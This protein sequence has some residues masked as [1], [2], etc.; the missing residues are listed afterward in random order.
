MGGLFGKGKNVSSSAPVISSLRLQTSAKGKVIPVAFGMPRISPNIIDYQDFTAIPHTETQ[1]SGGGKGGNRTTYS[2][3]TYT[4]TVCVLMGLCYGPIAAIARAWVDKQKYTDITK[5]GF[6]TY[7]GT[8]TQMP[9][10][11]MQTKHADRALGYRNIAYVAASTYDLGDSATL[12]NHSFEIDTGTGFSA[13]IRDASPALIVASILTNARYGVGFPASRI[14]DLS[15]FGDY[16]AAAGLF[17]SPVYTDS[18]TAQSVILELADLCDTDVCFAGGKLQFK[19]RATTA[20]SGNGK[21]FTPYLT[22]LYHLTDDDFLE[23]PRIIRNSNADAPNCVTLKFNNRDTDYN[24]EIVEAKDQANIEIFGLHKDQEIAADA[25]VDS[26]VAARVVQLRLQRKLYRRNQYEFTIGWKYALLE[27]CDIVTLTDS[28]LGLDRQAVR[29]LSVDEDEWGAL[30]ITAEEFASAAPAGNGVYTD[31]Y[32]PDYN[33]PADTC[34]VPA[35]FELAQV[36]PQDESSLGIAVAGNGSN[37]GGC[38]VW[39][40]WDGTNYKNVGQITAPCRYGSLVGSVGNAVNAV[41]PVALTGTNTTLVSASDVAADNF[42]T[43]CLVGDELC[44]YSKATLVSAGRYDVSLRSRGSYGTAAIAHVSGDSF[45][46]LDEAVFWHNIPADLIGS[47]LYIKLTAYNIYFAGEQSL[48]DVAAYQVTLAGPSNGSGNGT[49]TAPIGFVLAAPFVGAVCSIKWDKLEDVTAYRLRIYDT[50]TLTLR[51]TVTLSDTHFDYSY[52]MATDDGGPWRKLTFRL[53]S[54]NEAE[55]E[56][57]VYA[58]LKVE[59]PQVGL[60]TGLKVTGFP[61]QI[62][63]EYA[64]PSSDAAGILVFV[65][66]TPGFVPSVSTRVY[67]GRDAVIGITTTFAGMQYVRVAGYDYWGKDSLTYSPEMSVSTAQWNPFDLVDGLEPVQIVTTLP[68][69]YAWEGS[70][71]ISCSGMLYQLD[72][73]QWVPMVDASKLSGKITSTQIT[74]G[75]V[76]TPKLAAGAVTAA[77]IAANAVTAAKIQA[78][79]VSA[80]KIAANAIAATNIQAGAVTAAKIAVATLSAIAANIGSIISGK[81]QNASGSALFDLDATGLNPFIRFRDSLANDV[82]KVSADGSVYARGDIQASSLKANTAMVDTL[83]IKDAAISV[84]SSASAGGGTPPVGIWMQVCDVT[85]KFTGSGALVVA[86]VDVASAGLAVVQDGEN[87]GQAPYNIRY[88]I[89]IDGVVAG[90]GLSRAI[91]PAAGN[92]NIAIQ[93]LVVAPSVSAFMLKSPDIGEKSIT[94]L[95]MRR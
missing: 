87:Y 51:R 17:F 8:S 57:S 6:S 46:R 36:R 37:W 83:H 15:M 48:S 90:Y 35:V 58:E 13:S 59:N 70:G 49:G 60:V 93:I 47:K 53:W 52:L 95:E 11:Y 3:T 68:D 62:M 45:V 24:E 76:S 27:E 84:M 44:T 43:L 4:Y 72:N 21:T 12:P 5:L 66:P 56:S 85:H 38:R 69:P 2:N 9:Y 94:V 54:L 20:V 74:D 23:A 39:F 50:A 82:F 63:V 10:G 1:S 88:R 86:T 19:P 77:T 41:A 16:C 64:W 30:R 81:M 26:S 33:A 29:I 78:G 73:Y 91:K 92:H 80:D 71:V 75:A 40:S 25:I 7:L 55:V 31:P 28:Y 34:T 32:N 89:T 79:A 18:T 42:A 14:A 65:S 67:D 22:P 61:L